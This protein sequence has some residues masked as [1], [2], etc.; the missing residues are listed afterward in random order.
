LRDGIG[1]FVFVAESGAPPIQAF[2]GRLFTGTGESEDD[3]FGA[4]F[5]VEGFD[6]ALVDWVKLGVGAG[7][8]VGVAAGLQDAHVCRAG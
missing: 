2:E 1:G 3:V 4:R 8:D 6:G 7:E 5:I